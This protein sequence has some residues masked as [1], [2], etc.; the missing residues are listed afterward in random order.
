[1]IFVFQYLWILLYLQ[2]LSSS[3]PLPLISEQENSTNWGSSCVLRGP[4]GKRTHPA[5]V[6][7]Y[8]GNGFLLTSKRMGRGLTEQA[9]SRASLK[10]NARRTQES[11]SWRR[12]NRPLSFLFLY[13]LYCLHLEVRLYRGYKIIFISCSRK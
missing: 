6:L 10:I 5:F 2:I 3:F 8:L 1:M 11:I 13:L 12:K 9:M 7:P 4:L